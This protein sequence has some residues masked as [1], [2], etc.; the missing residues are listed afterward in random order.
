MTLAPLADAHDAARF[1]GKAAGLAR[2]I[3]AGL[4]VPPGFAIACDD[5]G[6]LAADRGRAVDVLARALDALGGGAIAVRSS[7]VGEDGADASFAGQ[8]ATRLGARDPHRAAAALEEVHASAR[9]PGALAYRARLGLAGAPH[10]AVIVQRAI[11][12]DV[13]GVLF[14]RNPATGADERVVEAAWGLGEVVVQG[15]VTP[16]TY[17]VARGGRVL[18][19]RP[20]VK[21]VRLVLDPDHGVRED[22]LDHPHAARRALDDAQLAALD[23][24]AT[25]CERAAAGPRDLE[26]AFE[27]GALWLLQ[28]R[29]ITR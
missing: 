8:H 17:R 11:A 1:G 18:E 24:L 22:A 19:A 14:T 10:M 15:L 12:A 16:D 4:P 21:D 29:S 6:A 28:S 20:G 26:W 7:A 9:H 3:A 23:A 27:G 2:A 5:A 25:A 13:A